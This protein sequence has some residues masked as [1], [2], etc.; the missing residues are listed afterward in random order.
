MLAQPKSLVVE[1]KSAPRLEWWSGPNTWLGEETHRPTL[2]A[3]GD[4]GITGP[5]EITLRTDTPESDRL[6]LAVGCDGKNTWATGPDGAQLGET[7]LSKPVTTLRIL[8]IGEYVEVYADGV[9]ALTVLCYSG[10]PTPRRAI[11]AGHERTIRI[12][13]IR[14]PDPHR[15]D[16]S[17]IWPGPPTP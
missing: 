17:A 9:F 5:V 3:V 7:V 16:A 13:P 11:S 15:D 4:I 2:H 1:S 14:L 8:T 12:R 10:Q 6:A